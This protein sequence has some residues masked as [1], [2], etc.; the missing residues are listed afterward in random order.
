MRLFAALEMTK[1][2]SAEILT[3]VGPFSF[4]REKRRKAKGYSAARR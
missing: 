3:P 2:I 1:W 4:Y